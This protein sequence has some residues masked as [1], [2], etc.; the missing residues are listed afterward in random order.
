M[1]GT[2]KKVPGLKELAAIAICRDF[3][4]KEQISLNPIKI[5]QWARECEDWHRECGEEGVFVD[6]WPMD[7]HTQKDVA[8]GWCRFYA[9]IEK[10]KMPHV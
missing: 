1:K 9:F 2:L 3:K 7:G 4:D 6:E 10:Q 8:C 5:V